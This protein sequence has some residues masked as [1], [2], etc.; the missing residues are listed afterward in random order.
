LQD[1]VF[2]PYEDVIPYDDFSIR[3]A[4]KDVPSIKQLLEAVSPA[5]WRRLHEG[6]KKWCVPARPALRCACL[7]H[8]MRP[9]S[10]AAPSGLAGLPACCRR[11]AALTQAGPGRLIPRRWHP[12][13]WEQDVGGTAYQTTLASLKKRLVQRRAG[14]V[15]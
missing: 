2:Q 11:L 7:L 4:S 6:L 14:F 5:E 9:C 1:H 12:F 13:V 8:W 10:C 3:L 15:S